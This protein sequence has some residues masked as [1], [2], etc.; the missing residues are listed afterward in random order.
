MKIAIPIFRSRL[1]PVF[2]WCE[3]LLIIEKTQNDERR[4][5]VSLANFSPVERVGFLVESK[6]TV[7]IFGVISETL[8]PVLEVNNIRLIPGVAG[9]VDEII[10]AFFAGDLH[11]EK[12]TMPGCR[13]LRRRQHRF[14]RG[15]KGGSHKNRC[16]RRR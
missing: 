8:L 7:F 13:G 14:G 15:H 1:S 9:R 12:Y 3:Q 5:E 10:E 4:M 2:D 16:N 11:L 6:V